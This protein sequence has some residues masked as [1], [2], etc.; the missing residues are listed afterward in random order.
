MK[1]TARVRR[2]SRNWRAMRASGAQRPPQERAILAR[3]CCVVAGAILAAV[4]SGQSFAAG[5]ATQGAQTFRY[6]MA[7]HSAERGV[8]MT[9]PSLAGIFGRKAGSLASFHRYSEALARS[10][11]VW[12][13][14]TLDAWIRNP[15]A[16]VPGNQMQFP[17]IADAA[18]RANLTAYLRKV[19]E[20]EISAVPP[21]G[22][23]GTRG[24]LPDLKAA[25]V[26]ARIKAIRY[27][28]DTYTLTTAGGRTLKFWEFNLRFKTDSSVRG[29]RRDE[30]VLVPQGMRG[31]RAQA[32]FA[33]PAE[34][35]AFIH[36]ECA[37]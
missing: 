15:A 34:I 18:A 24:G 5:D 31:D 14:G 19:S 37:K 28:D 2:A 8:N 26:E 22:A 23:A 3:R 35:S 27:C 4:T 6:C 21:P 29:P 16:L 33:D 7:C 17:G 20:E 12:D 11:I 9:G 10:G 30:P 13:E 25:G 32:I 36:K 1:P